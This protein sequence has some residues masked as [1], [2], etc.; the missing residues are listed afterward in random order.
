MNVDTVWKAC[1]QAGGLLNDRDDPLDRVYLHS[2]RHTA[3]PRMLKGG[4]NL[5]QAAIVSGHQTLAM[6]KR[7]EHLAASDAVG[8]AERHLSGNSSK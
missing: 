6:L 3:V 8:L 4:A 7:Y 5:A 1:R 2:T